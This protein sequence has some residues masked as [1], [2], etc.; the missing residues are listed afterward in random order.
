MALYNKSL[1]DLTPLPKK[2][3]QT[4]FS[5]IIFAERPCRK[6]EL[7]LRTSRPPPYD[8]SLRDGLEN[9]Q[10]H[11]DEPFQHNRL[12]NHKTSPIAAGQPLWPAVESRGQ[13]RIRPSASGDARTV[14]G[15]TLWVIHLLYAAIGD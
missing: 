12:R 11:L 9:N 6:L 2:I 5:T 15:W 1:S 7:L 13:A 10:S 14:G 4:S 3:I 8:R